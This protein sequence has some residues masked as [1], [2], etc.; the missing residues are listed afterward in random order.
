MGSACA[1]RD[2]KCIFWE[3]VTVDQQATE[4]REP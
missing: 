2:V 4:I 3:R 1:E